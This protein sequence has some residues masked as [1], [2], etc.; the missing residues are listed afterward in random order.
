MIKIFIMNNQIIEN[1][2]YFSAK[3]EEFKFEQN[4]LVN[5]NKFTD[6][7]PAFR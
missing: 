3:N 2:K 1:K 5:I 7:E 4:K 6:T